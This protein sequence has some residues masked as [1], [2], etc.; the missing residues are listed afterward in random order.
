[1]SALGQKRTRR[2]EIVMSGIHPK[3]DIAGRWLDVRYVP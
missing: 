3:A 1:M 2:P